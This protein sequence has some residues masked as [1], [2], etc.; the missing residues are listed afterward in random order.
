[1]RVRFQ[2]RRAAS[3]P[4]PWGRRVANPPYAGGFVLDNDHAM[5]VVRHQDERVECNIVVMIRELC[6]AI[7]YDRSEA[8]RRHLAIDDLTKT[9]QGDSEYTL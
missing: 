1:M 8:I 2:E 6:P 5:N 4:W 9:A 3:R 7:L